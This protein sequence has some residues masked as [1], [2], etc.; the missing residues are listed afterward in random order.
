M[1]WGNVLN[2][3]YNYDTI[4][5][6]LIV[7]IWVLNGSDTLVKLNSPMHTHSVRFNW[8]F[9]NFEV[10][11]LLGLF[12]NDIIAAAYDLISPRQGKQTACDLHYN[13]DSRSGRDWEKI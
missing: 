8:S 13:M 11:Y 12:K 9:K 1:R 10:L 3:H 2:Y 6:R 4:V 5:N 7:L